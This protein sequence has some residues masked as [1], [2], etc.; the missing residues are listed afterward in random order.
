MKLWEIKAQS[1]KLM[2]ADSELE[3][4]ED[5]FAQG[6]VYDNSNTREKLIRMKIA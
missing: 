6:S 1:L 5:E 4:S 2:F 3:F